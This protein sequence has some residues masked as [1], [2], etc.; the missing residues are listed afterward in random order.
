MSKAKKIII[1]V[2]ICDLV[3]ICCAAVMFYIHQNNHLE[4]KSNKVKVE[5]GEPISLD[6]ADYLKKSVDK[7]IVENT[8]VT[9]RDNPVEGEEYDNI[10]RYTVKLT[11]KKEVA[12]VKV[13]VEDTTK[14][15]FNNINSFESI[16][17]VE[18]KWDDYIKATDLA[19]VDLKIDDSSVD[20]NKV[21]EYT[22]KATAKD[23]SGNEEKKEIKVSIKE[24]PDNMTG[25]AI[26]I[27]EKMGTVIIT[28]VT[29]SENNTGAGT[30]TSTQTNGYS[31]G[32]SN[33]GGSQSSS[34]GNSGT[35]SNVNN[36]TPTETTP[37][38]EEPT[39]GTPEEPS[40]PSE[41]NEGTSE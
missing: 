5:Y 24:K 8:K 36:T 21:G 31:G 16:A 39:T 28:A 37:P 20:I 10:G 1:I 34:S 30:G 9:Y 19:E 7:E 33:S 27:D 15:K 38:V 25:H 3:A 40:Q 26:D 41:Y 18:V 23:E 4:L 12:K 29:Q 14:P 6:A 32:Y 17:G 35:G 22:L 13:I 2:A 11:Y